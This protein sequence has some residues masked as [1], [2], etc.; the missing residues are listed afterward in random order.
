MHRAWLG[1]ASLNKPFDYFQVWNCKRFLPYIIVYRILPPD[2]D[3]KQTDAQR[4]S[5][6]DDGDVRVG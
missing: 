4:L 5:D 1:L 2:A 6:G 3:Q